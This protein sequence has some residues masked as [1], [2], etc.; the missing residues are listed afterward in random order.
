MS[1][2]EIFRH[3]LSWASEDSHRGRLARAFQINMG[4]S[5]ELQA[6]RMGL[7]SVYMQREAKSLALAG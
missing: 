2:D 7:L 5:P 3:I 6:R 1:A 4:D